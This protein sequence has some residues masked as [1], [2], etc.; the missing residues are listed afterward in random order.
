MERPRTWQLKPRTTAEIAP[1]QPMPLAPPTQCSDPLELD[2]A[3]YPVQFPLAVVQGKVLVKPPQHRRQISLLGPAVPVHMTLEPVVD[4][5]QKLPATVVRGNA[6]H[7]ELGPPV[8]TTHMLEA[9]EYER[10]WLL[11]VCGGPPSADRPNSSRRVFSG[12]NP[13]PNFCIRSASSRP[14]ASASA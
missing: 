8:Q 1:E 6:H 2:F 13:R 7:G 11:S 9:Q 5:I 10:A 12:F 3:T 14:K 4:A